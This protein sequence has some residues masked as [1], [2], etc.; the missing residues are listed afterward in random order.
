MISGKAWKGNKINKKIAFTFT[1]IDWVVRAAFV[2]LNYSLISKIQVFLIMT[3]FIYIISQFYE[4]CEE[5]T[6]EQLQW[7]DHFTHKYS[8]DD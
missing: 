4:E 6:L 3:A 7:Q 1:I 5:V 2:M 8:I